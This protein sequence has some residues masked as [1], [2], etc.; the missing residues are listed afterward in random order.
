MKRAA[1]GKEFSL[2]EHEHEIDKLESYLLAG[3]RE[4]NVWGRCTMKL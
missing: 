4:P 3:S 2:I 1:F